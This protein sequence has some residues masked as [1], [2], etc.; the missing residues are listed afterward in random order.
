MGCNDTGNTF[1]SPI[2]LSNTTGASV[3]SYISAST[4]TLDGKKRIFVAWQDATP[5]TTTTI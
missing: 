3:F 1:S 5:Q 2:Q 4:S